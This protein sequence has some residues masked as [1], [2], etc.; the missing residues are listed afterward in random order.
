MSVSAFV[1]QSFKGEIHSS[2]DLGFQM[3]PA[4]QGLLEHHKLGYSD[5]TYGWCTFSR[6]MPVIPV[7]IA[8]VSEISPRF[9]LY[10]VLKNLVCW[11]LWIGGLLRLRKYYAIP[12]KWV[13]LAAA[14]V[15][16]NPHNSSIANHAEVEEGYLISMLGL[17][18]ALL[19]TVVK[20]VDFAKIAILIALIYLT[21]SSMFL[22][23]AAT[24]VWVAIVEWRRSRLRSALPAVGLGIAALAWGA[25]IFFMTGVFAIGANESSYNGWNYYKGNNPYA[26]E[27]YPR[28]PLDLLDDNNL[29]MPTG[30]VHNEWELSD[31]QFALGPKFSRAHTGMV[32]RMDLKKL[33]VICCD[34]GESPEQL[35]GHT[36]PLII[37]S[38]LVN[39]GSFAVCLV[40]IGI[41]AW[42]RKLGRAELLALLLVAAYLPPYIAGWV[43]MRQMVPIYDLIAVVLAIMLARTGQPTGIQ[44]E[45]TSGWRVREESVLRT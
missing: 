3:G 33:Y 17:L 45:R 1:Y 40:W 20:T 34:L 4:A 18:Y 16:L 7:A 38:N 8:L 44:Q 39:H 42:K 11:S 35:Q 10:F 29:L 2:T 13:L 9:G 6:R 31:A 27:M 43:Y 21:K 12:D 28:V 14:I 32:L 24:V 36:R 26:L 22:I 37:L 30:P 41:R 5:E 25:Y 19:L 15:I 23:C